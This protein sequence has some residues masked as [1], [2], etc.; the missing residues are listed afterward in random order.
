M[1]DPG[2]FLGFWWGGGLGA[3]FPE[4]CEVHKIIVAYTEPHRKSRS[5]RLERET[6]LLEV[7][8]PEPHLHCEPPLEVNVSTRATKRLL[9]M[10]SKRRDRRMVLSRRLVRY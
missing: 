9:V 2:F 4:T 7:G 8:R 3:L 6:A 5:A 10:M 1:R